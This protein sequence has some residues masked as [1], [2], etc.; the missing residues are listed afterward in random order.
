VSALLFYWRML[1]FVFM[2]LCSLRS[3]FLRRSRQLL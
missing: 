2:W 3:Q 1:F